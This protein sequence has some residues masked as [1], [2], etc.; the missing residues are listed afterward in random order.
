MFAL[1]SVSNKEGLLPLAQGLARLG[2]QI[3]STGGTFEALSKAQIPVVSVA[4]HTQSPEI[5]HGRVKTLHPKIHGGLLGR[6]EREDD[7]AEMLAHG[8]SPIA[9]LAVNL[10]PFIET[11]ARGA[12]PEEVVE[13]IDV[14]GP[15]M[16]RAAAKNAQNVIVLT[17]P[18][19]Y[20][21]VLQ[22]LEEN[23][24]KLSHATRAYLQCKAFEHTAA[25]DAAIAQWLQKRAEEDFPQTLA[26]S[27]ERA[28]PLRYGENPHQRAAFYRSK[29]Q[30]VGP[31][32]AFSRVLQGKELS[33]NNLLDLDA[34]LSVVLEFPKTPAAAIIK[35]N[36]PCGVALGKN[37]EE[38]FARAKEADEVSAFGGIVALNREVDVAC[39]QGLCSLFLEAVI[40]PAYSKE[41]LGVLASKKN[42][43][44]LEAGVA[45]EKPPMPPCKQVDYRSISG[46][47]LAMDRD[48]GE[49]G[50]GA[51]NWR[52]VTRR[53]PTAQEMAAMEF[54][55][56][57][58]K[59]VKSNAIVY[60][61]AF[62]TLAIGGG[63]TSRVDS[64]RLAAERG[65]EKLKGCAVASDAFFPFRDGVEVL[66]RAGAVCAIQPGGSLRD[67][68]VIAA[69]DEHNLAMVF[70]GIRH[71]RH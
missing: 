57:V 32:L 38:A 60:A 1:L 29:I 37:L 21:R 25:Y 58:C 61:N 5:L 28:Q 66:A 44:L 63:Q 12:P 14:G 10:Y 68:E 49:E 8:I 15:T 18:S 48:I 16:L 40:A 33:Y 3:L 52:V 4:E 71:F 20:A 69:A 56:N 39:A 46:G 67:A 41:A 62:Q 45:L 19:D 59:H 26:L 65:G 13:Q 27:F 35:H 43:R 31:S 9:L 50:E 11:V 55:W 70:T 7:C 36:T 2:Y 54:A 17:S 23:Q 24:G 64:A 34:A 42:L 6:P 47:L 53:A 22:E 30:P 51:A